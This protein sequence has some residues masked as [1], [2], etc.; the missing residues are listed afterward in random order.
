MS[1]HVV[2][3]DLFGGFR[4]T[5]DGRAVPDEDWRRR[6]AAALVKLLALSS[7]HRLHR[8]RVAAAL[9]TREC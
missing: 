6:H 5:V 9:R 2:G 7:G 4:V 1:A 8:E 3:I